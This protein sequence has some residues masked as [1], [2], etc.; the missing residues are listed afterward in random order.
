MCDMLCVCM[1][2]IISFSMQENKENT[3]HKKLFLFCMG[4]ELH[5]MKENCEG[6]SC[7][8]CCCCCCSRKKVR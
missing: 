5:E 6:K 4:E 2:V 7:C 1:Y 3:E 8:C